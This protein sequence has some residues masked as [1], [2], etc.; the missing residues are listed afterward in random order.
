MKSNYYDKEGKSMDL[1]EWARSSEN[2]KYKHVADDY[3]EKCR[4]S[5]VWLG[6]NHNFYDGPPLIFET[7]VFRASN[8]KVT[9]WGELDMDRY[10][11]LKQAKNGHKKMVK[12]WKKKQHEDTKVKMS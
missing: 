10:S 8:G 6:L 1:T 5:T 2:K 4:V 3:L 7:M 9:D 11:T 12:R